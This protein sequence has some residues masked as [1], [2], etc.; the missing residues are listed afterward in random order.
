MA[1]ALRF[2]LPIL[3]F[4][5]AGPAIAQDK[6]E[7]GD[8][9]DAKETL[10]AIV[11][12]RTKILPNARSAATLGAQREGSGVLVREGYVATI[13]YL[14]IESASIEV[15]DADG[16]S[17]PATLAAYDH[18]S[19][20]GLLKLLAPIA[21]KP[22]R[23]AIRARLPSASLRWSR[24]TAAGKACIWCTWYRAGRSPAAGNTCSTP[25]SSPIRR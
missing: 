11:R 22:C 18:A 10:S 23:S 16:K 7:S 13:G 2:L 14:V 24:P 1:G 15:T 17:V 5:F 3:V 6:G 20:F 12:V 21:G 25:P 8:E 9:A 4:A 19:G